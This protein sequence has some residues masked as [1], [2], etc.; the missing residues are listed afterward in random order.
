MDLINP[1]NLRL[2]DVSLSGCINP[3][4]GKTYQTADIL[5]TVSFF[6]EAGFDAMEICGPQ[7]FGSIMADGLEDPFERIEM[8]QKHLKKTPSMVKF[9][10]VH[11][12]GKNRCPTYVID[13]FIKKIA[14]CGVDIVKIYDPLN[15]FS[16]MED[17]IHQLIK[18]NMTFRGCLVVSEYVHEKTIKYILK[19]ALSFQKSGAESLCIEDPEGFVHPDTIFDIIKKVRKKI[20]IPVHFSTKNN[21]GIA[22]FQCLKAVEASASSIETALSDFSYPSDYPSPEVFISLF[23]KTRKKPTINVDSLIEIKRIMKKHVHEKMRYR[24]KSVPDVSD[25]ELL[26]YKVT[27]AV[28][29]G[30]EKE[31]RDVHFEDKR[32]AALRL[33]NKVKKDLGSIPF[34]YPFD[35]MTVTQAVNNLVFDNYVGEYQ[36]VT[37]HVKAHCL[38]INGK[39]TNDTV[40]KLPKPLKKLRRAKTID[41]VFSGEADNLEKTAHLSSKKLLECIVPGGRDNGETGI[42][43]PDIFPEKTSNLKTFNVVINDHFYEVKVDIDDALPEPASAAQRIQFENPKPVTSGAESAEAIPEAIKASDVENAEEKTEVKK[44]EET[45]HYIKAPMPGTVFS[46]EKQEQ[47]NVNPGDTLLVMEAMKMENAI[48]S[49]I[50]GVVKKIFFGKGDTISKNDVLMEIVVP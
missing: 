16:N 23:E 43:S 1:N 27:R 42:N 28:K 8:I 31:L 3:F 14:S 19:T 45:I 6:D 20:N 15:R 37:D 13:A 29:E 33:V 10:G 24:G 49:Q 44:T 30:L 34:V 2:T 32:E 35:A 36:I 47:E 11:L 41:C 38:D 25:P 22:A 39:L 18:L 17:A 48:L 7:T 50:H 46:I 21:G 12:V 5:S 40:K 4:T 26:F 9:S